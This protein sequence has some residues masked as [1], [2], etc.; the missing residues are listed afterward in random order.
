MR[1]G[2]RST[3]RTPSPSRARRPI[4]AII[5]ETIPGTAG[6]MVPPPGYLAGVREICD[7]YGIV[8]ILDEVMAGFGRT[9][10]WFAADHCDVMPDLMT[11]AKGVNSGYV[12]LGGV[13]ISGE[14][15]ET[16]ATRPYP[17]GLTYS[18][19]PLACA[20]AVATINAMAE[21]GIVENAGAARR[22]GARP[23]AARAGRAAPV[24]SARCAALG[25]FWALELVEEQGDPRA[26]GAVQRG[27]RGRTRRWRRSAAACKARGLWPFVNMNRTHVVP[28][29]NVSEAEAKEGLAALDAALSAADEAHRGW[30]D[31]RLDPVDATRQVACSYIRRS[32][33]QPHATRRRRPCRQQRQRRRD[34]QHPAPADRRRA[35]RRGAGGTAAAGQRVHRQGDRRAVRRLRDARP[36]GAGR[37][38]RAGPA[39]RRA[40]PRLP[41]ARVLRRRLPRAWSRRAT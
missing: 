4:A 12:P 2:A 41:G 21:E 28:P 30:A 26:A 31:R 3:W 15:A 34:A 19:H 39:R 29:C 10:E 25:V 11:F 40:A 23:R 9:G 14:I 35:A 18:G 37:P 38:V 7:R 27:R 32:T 8:F 24:A 36:R 22:D 17:G 33:R 13:A 1:A 5:L 6:I 20:S 16:F